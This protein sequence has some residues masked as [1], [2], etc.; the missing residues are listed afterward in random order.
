MHDKLSQAVKLYDKLLTEQLSKPAWRSS[1]VS[2]QARHPAYYNNQTDGSYQWSSASNAPSAGPAYNVSSGCHQQEVQL[3]SNLQDP[4]QQLHRV[5]S[6]TQQAISPSTEV[7]YRPSVLTLQPQ[8][9]NQ[10]GHSQFTEPPGGLVSATSAYVPA[11]SLTA[12]ISQYSSPPPSIPSQL[13]HLSP[14]QYDPSPLNYANHPSSSHTAVPSPAATSPGPSQWAAVPT[15]AH[16]PPPDRTNSIATEYN[17]SSSASGTPRQQEQA[18]HR[19]QLSSPPPPSTFSQP[20]PQSPPVVNLSYGTPHQ[21][22]Q[23]YVVPPSSVPQQQPALQVPAQASVQ[24]PQQFT[25]SQ[26]NIPQFPV[27]PTNAPQSYPLYGPS[28]PIGSGVEQ[29]E[30]KEALLIDL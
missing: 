2:S 3:T 21:P 11:Q 30:R 12:P 17:A 15:A 27:A 9:N 19:T 8:I 18:P 6:P 25:Q 28:V 23:P 7:Q 13:P 22:A 1:L 10:F 4:Q 24:P 29:T 16:H 26:A 20:H 14:S 5:Q